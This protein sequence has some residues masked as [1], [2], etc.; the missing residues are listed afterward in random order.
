MNAPDHPRR[1]TSPAEA[2]AIEMA[3]SE[4]LARREEGPLSP[5]EQTAFDAWLAADP[6]HAAAVAELAAAWQTFD[7]LRGYPRAA[8]PADP[9]FFARPPAFRRRP[10]VWTAAAAAVLVLAA[11]MFVFQR[12]SGP[13]TTPVA[14]ATASRVLRLADGSEIEL[15]PGSRVVPLFTAA[16]RRVDLVQGEAY[17]SV[18]RDAARPFIVEARGVAVR[19]LGTAFNVRVEASAVEVLL[20]EGRVQVAGP[21]VSASA[22]PPVV[23]VPG[24]RTL[25]STA[26]AVT[27][28]AVES[29][30]PAE[31]DRALAWQTSRLSFD[32]T[33]LAEVVAQFNRHHGRTVIT[34]DP[35][36]ASLPVSGR[37]RAGNLESFVELLES[38]FHL[39]VERRSNGD[40]FLHRAGQK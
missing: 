16:E 4:W 14:V 39:A 22:P 40:V 8:A 26:A 32:A 27:E 10:A 23:L 19:A 2:E 30:A 31:I 9:E 18:V 37:F 24:Q 7:G 20:T 34:L 15:K 25:V 1:S 36:L 28:P 38:G 17:F 13:D 11:A 35:A 6:R 5:T 29:L 12:G 33:P 21:T 3:A